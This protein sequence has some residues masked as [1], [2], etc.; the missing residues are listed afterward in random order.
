[1]RD[2]AGHCGSLRG[3]A[4]HC[5]ALQGAKGHCGA[6]LGT[7]GCHGM[8]QSARGAAGRWGALRGT[9]VYSAGHHEAL[10]C[11]A[12]RP[13]RSTAV[14]AVGAPRGTTG[15][16][17]ALRGTEGHSG[18]LQGAMGH[19]GVQRGTRSTAVYSARHCE[20][21]TSGCDSSTPGKVLKGS[22]GLCMDSMW[23][24][25]SL[26][27]LLTPITFMTALGNSS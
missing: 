8:L 9:V 27:N 20:A 19:C 6:L 11:E 5:W 26:E 15:C 10:C 22:D 18:M 16:C 12:L 7:V 24:T 4:G 21:C 17:G 13:L 25:K 1:L 14:S 2:I 23:L 3:I